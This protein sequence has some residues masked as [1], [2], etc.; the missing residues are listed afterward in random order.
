MSNNYLA[1]GEQNFFKQCRYQSY[2][3]SGTGGQKRNKKA[4][5][6]RLTHIPTQI[7]VSTC[8]NRQQSVNKIFACRLLR[9]K[10]ALTIPLRNFDENFQLKEQIN[11]KNWDFPQNIQ[12][13]FYYLEKFHYHIKET[14]QNMDISQSNLIK[15]LAKNKEVWQTFNRER[16]KR[17]LKVIKLS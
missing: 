2:K 17:E 6:I 11:E 8:Q 7:T 5:G 14:A 10:I 9:I 1:L 16:S 3:A 13:I 12:Y 4:S 15:F